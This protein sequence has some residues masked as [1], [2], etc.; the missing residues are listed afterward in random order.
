MYNVYVSYDKLVKVANKYQ[1]L[2]SS[3]FL[4]FLDG[5]NPTNVFLSLYFQLFED[6]VN[7]LFTFIK[8]IQT[9]SNNKYIIQYSH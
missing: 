2:F 3:L 6:Y 7:I 4:S 8:N 9:I 1:F 5:Y